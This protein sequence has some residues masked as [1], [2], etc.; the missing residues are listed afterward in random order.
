MS[1]FDTMMEDRHSIQ[2]TILLLGKFSSNVM[3]SA[4]INSS[5]RKPNRIRSV[6]FER[7][8]RALEQNAH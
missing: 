7:F 8:K 2:A 3:L 1:L 6:I 4:A 5:W